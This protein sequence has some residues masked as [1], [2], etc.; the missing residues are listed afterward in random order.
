MPDIIK[1][2]FFAEQSYSKN[3]IDVLFLKHSVLVNWSRARVEVTQLVSTN[4]SMKKSLIAAL[5]TIAKFPCVCRFSFACC[6]SL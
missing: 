4:Q 6:A 1:I 5:W 3:K 2:F